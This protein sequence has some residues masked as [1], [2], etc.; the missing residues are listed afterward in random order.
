MAA[1]KLHQTLADYVVTTFSPLLIM[2]L[3]GSLVFFLLEVLYVGEYSA[4]LQWIL[5]FWV[6]GVV[7]VARIS[8]HGVI[9]E[10]AGL[11]GSVLGILVFLGLQQLIDYPPGGPLAAFGWAINLGLLAI[12]W[13]SAHRLTWDSTF[14]DDDVDAS[15]TGL[16]DAAGLEP[17]ASRPAAD[18]EPE[19]RPSSWWERC[20]RYREEQ[21]R[22]PHTP[23][24]W[25]VYFSLAALPLFGLGQSLIPADAWGRRCYVFWL[26]FIYTGSGLG[27]LLTTSFLGLRR[28][29]RQRRVQMP[30]AI[31]AVWLG[32]GAGLVLTFLVLGAALPRPWAE[33]SLLS[34]TP[35]GSP[36][37]E[38]SRRAVKPD[39]TARGDGQPGSEKKDGESSEPDGQRQPPDGQAKS[40]KP[41]EPKDGANGPRTA[42][43]ATRSDRAAQETGQN[44]TAARSQ[45]RGGSLPSL[46]SSL[47]ALAPVLR[48]TVFAILVLLVVAFLLRAGLGFLANFTGWAR[49]LLDAWQRLLSW[50]RGEPGE[51]PEEEVEVGQV[52][53]P[54]ASFSNPFQ[55]GRARFMKP[56]E[57]VRYTFAALEAW[58]SE[59]D[60]DRS[61]DETP[62]EFAARLGT[63]YPSLAAK[64]R[65]LADLVARITYGR[66]DLSRANLEPLPS[67]WSL[68]E[69]GAEE[70][71][72]A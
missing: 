46:L 23:G 21:Q 49:R 66:G 3:V 34:L 2:S 20:R 31:T 24:V 1:S 69:S 4:R 14:I 19:A 55:D 57:L 13:W 58:A 39:G 42:D 40:D 33:Y 22:K 10:R 50:W 9:A 44:G 37:R 15:G 28:Y 52:V 25:V 47:E 64:A 71:I 63:D 30:A 56:E 26:M 35:L 8:M 38:A 72:S 54:F 67:L 53:R 11:Y 70:P 65:Q 7:L 17:Q 48:W 41:G 45:A 32:M 51:Q 62:L 29:L 18:A 59:H 36:E 61:P 43:T 16:L 6:F 5:F 60:L 27:L 68:L 12:T